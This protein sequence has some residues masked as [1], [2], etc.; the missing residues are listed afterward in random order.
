MSTKTIWR[1]KCAKC[2]AESRTIAELPPRSH[3]DCPDGCEQRWSDGGLKWERWTV[4][5]RRGFVAGVDMPLPG[6]AREIQ[7]FTVAEGSE[8][9][10]VGMSANPVARYVFDTAESAQAEVDETVSDGELG[11]VRPVTVRRFVRSR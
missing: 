1:A 4:V 10:D 8:G 5:E 7:W 2:G 6:G 9:L 11:V 3:T